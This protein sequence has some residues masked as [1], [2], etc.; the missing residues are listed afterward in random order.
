MTVDDELYAASPVEGVRE[1]LSLEVKSLATPGVST[2]MRRAGGAFERHQG[3]RPTRIGPRDPARTK[4]VDLG[5]QLVEVGERQRADR[6]ARLFLGCPERDEHGHMNYV[7]EPFKVHPPGF[8][9]TTYVEVG[10]RPVDPAEAGELLADL[11]EAVEAFYGFVSWTPHNRQLRGRF[12]EEQRGRYGGPPSGGKPPSWQPPPFQYLEMQV[13]DVFWVQVFGPAYVQMWGEDKLL[14]AGARRRRLSH[15]GYVVWA[16]EEPPA[17]D[18]D[19]D[20]PEGYAWKS[21]VYDAIG[22]EPFMRSDR[23]WNDFGQHVP[24]MTD[25]AEALRDPVA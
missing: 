18:D 13:P 24:L 2:F 7:P 8:V 17:Y 3:C 25:H 11:A 20:R 15:G 23:G 9:N 6:P 4:V 5:A 21:S 22:P 16:T 10:L 12:E 19:V 14:R 1:F